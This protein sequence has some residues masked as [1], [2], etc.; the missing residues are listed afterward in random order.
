MPEKL[1]PSE[2]EEEGP[3]PAGVFGIDKAW[4][5][6]RLIFRTDQQ[7]DPEVEP[8]KWGRGGE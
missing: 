5:K 4:E 1:K 8:G 3:K 7:E 6:L 2:F